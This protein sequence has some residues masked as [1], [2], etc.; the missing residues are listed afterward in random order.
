V[1]SLKDAI[2]AYLAHLSADHDKWHR[3]LSKLGP[4]D[5]LPAWATTTYSVDGNGKI[6]AH[7]I[8]TREDGSRSSEA[9]IVLSDTGKFKTGDILKSASWKAPAKNFAR[10]NVFDPVSY[11]HHR[12]TGAA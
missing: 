6:Y 7:V 4:N 12:W 10:G 8:S 3:S 5:P 9:F 1:A 2:T 11:K